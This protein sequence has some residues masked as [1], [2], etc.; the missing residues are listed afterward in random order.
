MNE[1]NKLKYVLTDFIDSIK[2]RKSESDKALENGADDY[3]KG[4]NLAYFEML[5]MLE[6]RCKVYGVSLND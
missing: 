4:R 2:E 6:T 1:N 5:E 3:E